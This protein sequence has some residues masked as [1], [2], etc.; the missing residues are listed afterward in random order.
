MPMLRAD[1]SVGLRRDVMRGDN[2]DED[3]LEIV[4]GV[5][6]AKLGERAFGKELARLDDTDGVAELLDFAHDVGRED[7]R[8]A[9]IAAFA[10]EGGDGAGSHDV[11]AD[12]GLIEDHDRWIVDEGAGNGGF[13]LHAGGKLVAASVAEAVHVQAVEDRSEERR[14]GKECRSRWWPDH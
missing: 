10:N 4:L 1:M 2:L 9:A 3:F 5:F 8:L 7:D 13:L 11:E 14:V 12:R 6:L